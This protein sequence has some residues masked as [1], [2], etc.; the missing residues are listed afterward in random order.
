MRLAICA[1]LLCA[2]PAI[3]QTMVA[4]H[5]DSQVTLFDK[6]CEIASVLRFIPEGHRQV[7]RKADANIAGQRWF[8]CFRVV[9]DQVHMVYEDGDQG[10]IDVADFKESPGS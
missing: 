10:L 4:R 5:G 7:F 2:S 9:R 3:A 1:A 8:A 6:P